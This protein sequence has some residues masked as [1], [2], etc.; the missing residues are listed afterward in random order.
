MRA[1]IPAYGDGHDTP[2]GASR[3]NPRVI[4]NNIVAALDQ[5]DNDRDMSTLAYIWGQVESTE[6]S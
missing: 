6:T 4:S 3:P 1:T 5:P 2:S